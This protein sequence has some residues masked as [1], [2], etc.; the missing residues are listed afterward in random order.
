MQRAEELVGRDGAGEWRT[1]PAAG[2]GGADAGGGADDAD[3]D[4]DDGRVRSGGADGAASPATDKGGATGRTARI[5][6][7]RGR[8][9]AGMERRR[10]ES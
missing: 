2:G 7:G 8:S 5:G 10:A 1:S 4:A 3:G 9:G 6:N